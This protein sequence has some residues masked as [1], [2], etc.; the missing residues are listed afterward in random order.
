[1]ML[2]LSMMLAR[3]INVYKTSLSRSDTVRIMPEAQ[4]T[5]FKSDHVKDVIAGIHYH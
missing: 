2:A 5:V 4:I 3:L 1:M